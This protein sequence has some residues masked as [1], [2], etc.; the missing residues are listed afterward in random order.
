LEICVTPWLN[1]WHELAEH[2]TIS[3]YNLFTLF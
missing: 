1:R 2:I 3:F